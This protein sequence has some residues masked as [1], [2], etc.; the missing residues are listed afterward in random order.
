MDSGASPRYMLNGATPL[1]FNLYRTS[2]S[3]AVWGAGG[4]AGSTLCGSGQ[5]SL[6]LVQDIASDPDSS[7]NYNTTVP[8]Y[9]RIFPGQ[10]TLPAGT[11]TSSFA[12]TGTSRAVAA[13]QLSG[14]CSNITANATDFPFA[15]SASVVPS[16]RVSASDLGF[17]TQG[18]LDNDLDATSAVTVTCTNGASYSVGLNQG[19]TS[20][21]TTTIRKMVGQTSSATINYQMFKDIARTDNWGNASGSWAT[22]TGTGSAQ[23]LTVYGRMPAQTTPK[24]DTY[25]DTVT[26]TVTY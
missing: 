5:S 8:V 13:Y 7:G 6:K 17:G 23:S 26:V 4:S 2:S 19:T 9:G 25:R 21:G 10:T 14:S 1:Q 24:P 15:A 11:Y 3:T 16:C 22:G 18:V 20:G 12:S